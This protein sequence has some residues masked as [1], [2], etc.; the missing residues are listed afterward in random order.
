MVLN[1]RNQILVALAVITTCCGPEMAVEPP[2]PQ[3]FSVLSL[4]IANGAGFTSEGHRLAQRRFLENHPADLI[5]LQEV[6]VNLPRSGVI[7]TAA[8]VLP[9]TGTII[10]GMAQSFEGG[11]YG[12][13]LW[14]SSRFTVVSSEVV[15]FDD[16]GDEEPRSA[17]IATVTDGVTTLKVGAIHLSV[18]GPRPLELRTAQLVAL[19]SMGLDVLAGDFNAYPSE[20]D[21]SVTTNTVRTGTS[22]DQVRASSRFMGEGQLIATDGASD[23]RDAAF[24]VLTEVQ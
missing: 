2:T 3:P 16:A 18:Y 12:N 21:A 20:V 7:D 17:I 1:M 4:N 8:A 15:I 23:H 10:Y 19:N 6:D 13:A 24:V 9:S 22:I 11:D 5:A 14:V